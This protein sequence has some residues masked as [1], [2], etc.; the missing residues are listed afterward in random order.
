MLTVAGLGTGVIIIQTNLLGQMEISVAQLLK[1]NDTQIKNKFTTL[2]NEV[3][4]SLNQMPK[5]VGTQIVSKTTTALNKEENIVS[6]DFEQS[7]QMSMDSLAALLAKVA[8]AA[9]LT[10]DF[11]T[12]IS[13]VKS[14]SSGK[15]IIY[16][17]YLR[18]NGRPL[19]RYYD[20]QNSKIKEF[21]AISTEKR[22]I[23]KILQAS[24]NDAE[25]MIIKKIIELDGK[26]L[27]S[28]LLCV[29]KEAMDQKL[30]AMDQRFSNLIKSNDQET[31]QALKQES[32][33]II[34]HFSSRLNNISDNN[35]EAVKKAGNQIQKSISDMKNQIRKFII[36]LGTI[37][38]IIISVILFFVISKITKRINN[39]A[40][41]I[42]TGSVQ[43]SQASEQ[44][45]MSSHSLAD[46]SSR[47]AASIEEI[48][49]SME[50]MSSMTKNNA[51]NA[52]QA[53]TLMKTAGKIVSKANESMTQ[54]ITSMEEISTASDETSKIIKTIDEIAFQTNLLALN[55]AVEAARAGE[56]GAGFAVVAD[57]VRNLAMRAA[58]AAKN[59]SNLIEN[60]VNKI[61]SG[62]AL[63]TSTNKSFT[64][65]AT[66]TGKVGQLVD[67]I[68]SASQEQAE[69][70]EQINKALVE[71]DSAIQQNAATSEES[72][73]ASEEMNAQ[74]VP[75]AES[76]EELVAMI[77][78][79]KMTK[80]TIVPSARVV[81]E[82]KI[83]DPAALGVQSDQMISF[84]GNHKI[85]D[86]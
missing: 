43:V 52:N 63:V 38:I 44:V 28:V 35:S 51:D 57:E 2:G 82:K 45:S 7:L 24:K 12:L 5:S 84:N 77:Q 37:S 34:E 64:E 60:T 6:S 31:T 70:V 78:G 80:N 83:L 73:S 15:D 18:P 33:K 81:N 55:A 10:N 1:E 17:I 76:V 16:A 65:V 68:S 30:E 67:E 11:T 49:A 71:M 54:L 46:T 9:I 47:Q 40:K 79:S 19:T 66:V 4:K 36:F 25:V 86:V 26:A 48:A 21:I 53:D 32:K 23:N 75:M 29:S 85:H 62:S 72:A 50:E 69:G 13:Y 14:A 8:P 42:N 58:V 41:T 74:A 20:K 56:A 22:K 39:I 3:T 59:T 27:G 61:N